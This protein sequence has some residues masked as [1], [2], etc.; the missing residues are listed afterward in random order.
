MQRF[1]HYHYSFVYI[2]L[3]RP[4][5]V[6]VRRSQALRAFGLLRKPGRFASLGAI[7]C[8]LVWL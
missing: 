6:R 1:F 7:E 8:I 4:R 2:V 5:G 3:Y